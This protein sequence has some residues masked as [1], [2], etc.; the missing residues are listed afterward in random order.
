MIAGI[1]GEVMTLVIA[2]DWNSTLQNQI[3]EICRRCNGK[4]TPLDFNEWDPKLGGKVGMTDDDFT[5]WAWGDPSIQA[6]APAYP[7]AT[8]GVRYLA[9]FGEIWIVTATSHYDVC[10]QWLK[11]NEIDYHRLIFAQDK[12][13]VAWDVL[14]D[15]S[16][17]TLRKMSETGRSVIRFSGPMWNSDMSHLPTL[18][19][20]QNVKRL[21]N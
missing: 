11:R 21:K 8:A 4:I 15:D 1:L 17:S 6:E 9:Q 12:S 16:P 18:K 2:I 13:Q 3:S 7:G 14:I 5:A 10:R 20:W 19:G